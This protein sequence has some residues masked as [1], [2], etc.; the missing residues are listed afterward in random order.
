MNNT[1]PT[2]EQ[3]ASA[4]LE[5]LTAARPA[6]PVDIALWDA[7]TIGTYLKRSTSVV[8]ERVVCQPSFPVAIRIPTG[9]GQRGHALWRAAEVI[10]WAESHRER[11]TA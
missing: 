2:A 6:I 11:E 4:L 8:R 5:K 1:L 10:A 9:A 7:E 3:I